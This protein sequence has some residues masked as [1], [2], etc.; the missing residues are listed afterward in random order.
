MCGDSTSGRGATTRAPSELAAEAIERERWSAG[1][2]R[3][4]REERLAR[5]LHK[6][7]IDVPFYREH[8][9]ARRRRGDHSS[10][11]HLENWPIL[12]KADIRRNPLAL[13]AE[14]SPVNRMFREHTSGTSGTPLTL[15]RSRATVRDWYALAEARWRQWYGVSRHD[16]WAILGGQ[17]VVPS[18]S[19]VPPFWVWNAG[20]R[21]LY[22]SSYHLAPDLITHYL[23]ALARFGITYILGYSSS[24]H[25]LALGA[26]RLGRRDV[27]LTVAITNAEPLFPYQRRTIEEAFGCPV[28]ETYGMAEIVAA[29]S[30]CEHGTM[31]LWPEA[32]E[33]E[34]FDGNRAVP[35]GTAG[36]LIGTGVLNTD[37]P[38]VR[39]R[40]GDRGALAADSARAC[41][42]GRTLPVLAAIDGRADDVLYTRD[43]RPVGR[44]DPVFKAELPLVEAQIVQERLDRLRVRYV[45][46]HG[47]TPGAGQA[48]VD[49]LRDRVGDVEVV[50]E[51]VDRVPRTAQGKFRA[52]VCEL[53]DQHI[54]T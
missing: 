10:W 33:L 26:R 32:G 18:A 51:E 28:R 7:A 23:D 50:L 9:A 20:L 43:G 2:W 17:L 42:C 44:L 3:Q 4:F 53:A 16:R 35:G 12:E 36:D 5:L 19:R 41:P 46:A 37:M 54:A 21:Q 13:V 39:Y 11:E 1:R 40:I 47:F 25:A 29:A 24:L 52:V 45:P 38:L 8:W 27:Q 22:M 34:V 48:L 30:E 6:A 31:H 14:S 49:R 15:Y